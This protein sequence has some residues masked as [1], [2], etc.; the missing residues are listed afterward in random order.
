MGDFFQDYFAYVGE[1]EVPDTFNRW[2][3]ISLIGSILG[4]QYWFPFRPKNIYPNLYIMFMGVPATR[5]T[6]AINIGTEVLRMAEYKQLAPDRMSRESFLDE[7]NYINQPENLIGDDLEALFDMN[8]DYPFEMTIH[9]EEFVNFIGQG[10]TDYLMTLTTLY[11][12]LPVYDNPKVTRKRVKVPKPTI[13]LLGACTPDTL[14]KALPPHLIGT[15]TMSR[16]LFIH[17]HST[18]KKLLIPYIPTPEQVKDIGAKLK[19][20][21]ET[22]KGQARIT[23]DA[24]K[25][26]NYIYQNQRP[27]EDPRFA[28]YSGRRI[29]HLW[30]LAMI[31]AAARL[32]TEISVE[33]VLAANTV[34]VV[35]E[36]EMPTALGHLGRSKVSIS[37]HAMV[38]YLDQQG[39][40][41][42]VR[43]LY[44]VFIS[45]FNREAEFHS[46]LMDLYNS[47]KIKYV[48]LPNGIKGMTV[49]QRSL[50]AWAKDILVPE[51]LT[52]QERDRI[53]I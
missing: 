24:F 25:V 1:S 8:I 16:I 33:D 5:K 32:Q 34:L 44:R 29:T 17:A 38:E 10:D 41:V 51:V 22:V 50:P 46:C 27:L 39:L 47:G 12:N 35:A 19:A 14:N 42:T 49:V 15:G 23:P 18:D 6:T 7:L 13:N 45:D 36:H 40:P 9:A 11:D 48:E 2:T 20:I 53:G 26:M 4:R 43:D 28:H 21:K 37:Q 3:A 30:K 31:H 52:Q